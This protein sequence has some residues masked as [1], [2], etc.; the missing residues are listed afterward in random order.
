MSFYIC[1]CGNT[2]DSHYFRHPF[3][4]VC[5]V[6]SEIKDGLETFTLNAEDFPLKKAEKCSVSTCTGKINIH[7]TV[8]LNHKYSPISYEYRDI[9]FTLPKS[10]LCHYKNCK[11]LQDHSSV[12]THHFTTKVII[13]NKKDEDIVSLVDKDD[14]DIKILNS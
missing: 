7:E 4:K 12:M 6:N 14:E 3:R 5:L 1:E 11:T 8:L 9:R 13:L 10:T 2:Q